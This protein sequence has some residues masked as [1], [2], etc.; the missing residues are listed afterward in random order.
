MIDTAADDGLTKMTTTVDKLIVQLV[1][2]GR[3]VQQEFKRAVQEEA[4]TIL[5]ADFGYANRDC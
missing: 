4:K 2:G 3:T 1:N 5:D